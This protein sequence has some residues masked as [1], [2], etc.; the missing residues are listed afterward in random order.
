MTVTRLL[1]TVSAVLK[2]HS[3]DCDHC[4]ALRDCWGIDMRKRLQELATQE[5]APEDRSTGA[6]QSGFAINGPGRFR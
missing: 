2:M 4:K 3:Q 5:Q 1:C 6:A